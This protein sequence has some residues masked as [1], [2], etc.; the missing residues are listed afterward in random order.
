[1]FGI[2]QPRPNAL[3]VD[4]EVID[5]TDPPR[6]L[7]LVL[8]LIY[9]FPP[10]NVDSLDLLVEGLVITDKYNVGGARVRL[11][12]PLG[13]FKEVPLRVYTIA[14]R[15]G[16]DE[17]AEAAPSLTT[18]IFLRSPR[19]P[20]ILLGSDQYVDSFNILARLSA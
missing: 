2:P 10:P 19:R 6:G 4:I 15:F 14:V 1:M 9:P 5:V 18:G 16:F 7:D 3:N 13:K 8:R 17:G 11:R 20:E 12:E